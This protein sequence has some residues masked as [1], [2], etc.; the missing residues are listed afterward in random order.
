MAVK[1]YAM[2]DIKVFYPGQ[3]YI[4]PYFVPNILS[5][6]VSNLPFRNKILVVVIKY[7]TKADVKVSKLASFFCFVLNIL[8]AIADIEEKVFH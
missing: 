6:I 2:A 4:I 3:F 5:K 7:Y 1:N 8:S